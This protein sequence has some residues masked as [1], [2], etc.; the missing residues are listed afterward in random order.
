MK[1]LRLLALAATLALTG[2]VFT[3]CIAVPTSRIKIGSTAIELPKN[4]KM[5]DVS[6]EMAGSNI[7]VRIGKLESQ[8]DPA[9]IDKTAA[10]Q[11]AIIREVGAQILQGIAQGAGKVVAP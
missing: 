2:C 11:V 8:N 9:V 5:S 7:T 4:M 10:G 1:K 6:W 3:G